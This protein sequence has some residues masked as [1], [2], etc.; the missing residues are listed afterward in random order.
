MYRISSSVLD[1]DPSPVLRVSHPYV[2]HYP[3]RIIFHKFHNYPSQ[4]H[5]RCS[6]SDSGMGPGTGLIYIALLPL[7]SLISCAQRCNLENATFGSLG[8]NNTKQGPRGALFSFLFF[9]LYHTTS[10]MLPLTQ[11]KCYILNFG[12]SWQQCNNG[13]L[14]SGS[15]L[16]SLVCVGQPFSF[17]SF[18]VRLMLTF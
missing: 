14:G 15:L 18:F 2:S 4:G 3:P 6:R 7:I 13:L 5:P 10:L 1:R 9:L 16:G 8:N 12:T 17:L 11:N